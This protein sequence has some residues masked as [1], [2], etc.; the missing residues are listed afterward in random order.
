MKRHPVDLT[1]LIAGLMFLTSAVLFTL[2]HLGEAHV[3]VRWVPAIAL[4]T[5]GLA[6]IAGSLTK[7]RR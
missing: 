5:L 7:V 6:I 1:S 4:V 2:D 3:D